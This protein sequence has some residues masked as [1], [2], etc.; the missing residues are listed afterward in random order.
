MKLRMNI[1]EISPKVK[2]ITNCEFHHWSPLEEALLTK[3][4]TP[5]NFGID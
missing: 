2:K 1:K 4:G 5:R 3:L